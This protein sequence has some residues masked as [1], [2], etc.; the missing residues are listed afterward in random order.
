MPAAG[1]IPGRYRVAV[2]RVDVVVRRSKVSKSTEGRSSTTDHF[3]P[4]GA[5]ATAVPA[6][7]GYGEGDAVLASLVLDSQFALGRTIPCEHVDPHLGGSWS[8]CSS[9]NC[10]FRANRARCRRPIDARPDNTAR[11]RL[12]VLLKKSSTPS[13]GTQTYRSRSKPWHR[14]RR[15]TTRCRYPCCRGE[16]WAAAFAGAPRSVRWS[17]RGTSTT[18]V[19]KTRT[20]GGAGGTGP[21]RGCAPGAWS[22]WCR[23]DRGRDAAGRKP[24]TIALATVGTCVRREVDERSALHCH[25]ER[26][27]APDGLRLPGARHAVEIGDDP[28]T[29]AFQQVSTV[30][31]GERRTAGRG[32]QMP[33]AG[34]VGRE[35]EL[36]LTG[37][38]AGPVQ[39]A[40][41]CRSAT[42]TAGRR[43]PAPT[44][45]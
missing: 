23:S 17:Q 5:V 14:N 31:C 33:V 13:F 15:S 10:R 41:R 27:E 39:Q 21:A 3:G 9:T 29:D 40:A 24:A 7:G 38:E 44:G 12:M 18:L 1:L 25:V 26:P 37:I 34:P 43:H 2:H 4:R 19:T 22:R 11:S 36:R 28:D 45:G 6:N 42:P 8:P 35:V 16:P 30:H 32:R 20:T